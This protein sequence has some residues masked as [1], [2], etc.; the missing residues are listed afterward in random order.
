MSR[1][2]TLGLDAYITC[3]ESTRFLPYVHIVSA[4]CGEDGVLLANTTFVITT[5]IPHILSSASRDC[6][7]MMS[8]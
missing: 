4:D 3:A 1:D 8:C 2:L 7:P 6:R 5:S